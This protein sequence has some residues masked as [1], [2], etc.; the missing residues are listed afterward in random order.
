MPAR[1]RRSALPEPVVRAMWS[2][3][4]EEDGDFDPAEFA[5]SLRRPARPITPELRAAMEHALDEASPMYRATRAATVAENRL[6][7]VEPTQA[8]DGARSHLPFLEPEEKEEALS[9]FGAVRRREQLAQQSA[10][11]QIGPA[12]APRYEAPPIGDEVQRLI[13]CASCGA[14]GEVV[15]LDLGERVAADV[16]CPSCTSTWSVEIVDEVFADVA[17][18]VRAGGPGTRER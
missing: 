14:R 7:T 11:E 3:L 16:T 9:L 2:A 5:R 12:P 13:T 1:L 8:S 17:A 6:R 15:Q 18:L 4:L 10:P